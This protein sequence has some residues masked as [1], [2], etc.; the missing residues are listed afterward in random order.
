MERLDA[1][2]GQPV[3]RPKRIPQLAHLD[4]EYMKSEGARNI[5][6]QCE[7]QGAI[8]KVEAFG[9]RNTILFFGSARTM[10]SKQH[11]EAEGHDS[12]DA[13]LAAHSKAKELAEIHDK[14]TALARRLTTWSLGRAKEEK[15]SYTVA[16]GGGPGMMAAANM[17]AADAGGISV[18]F[19]IRM[20][21]FENE[22]NQHVTEGLAL[23]F[24]YFFTRK[25]AMVFHMKALVVAPGGVGTFDEAFEIL[26][27]KQ[28]GRLHKST[29]VVFLGKKYW[30]TVINFPAMVE[31][32]VIKQDDLD[33]IL[34][35]DDV[36]EAQ[37]HL[38]KGLEEREAEEGG[39]TKRR[40]LSSGA[41]DGPGDGRAAQN[42]SAAP[43]FESPQKEKKKEHVAECHIGLRFSARV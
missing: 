19:G 38:T 16:T 30:E 10:S 13:K 12:E 22:V 31:Y 9:V 34:F 36:A 26:T 2:K 20:T 4:S 14:V 25:F 43:R 28:T 29:P 17:G 24:K 6:I 42:G 27:L 33:A 5:R 23:H 8:D 3:V 32:G 11:K 1:E 37:R 15:T 18:G 35:T 21:K 40:R 41:G 7:I 39:G